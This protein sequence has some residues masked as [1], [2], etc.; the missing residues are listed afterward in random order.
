MKYNYVLAIIGFICGLVGAFIALGV[1]VFSEDLI[2]NALIALISSI[3]GI[4]GIWLFNQDV[5][6]A[7]VLYLI[8]AVGVLIGV[9]LFGI[10]GF[11]FFIG[12][13]IAC[14]MEKTKSEAKPNISPNTQVHIFG[15]QP[16]EEVPQFVSHNTGKFWIIHVILVVLIIGLVVASSGSLFST[17]AEENNDLNVT[18][19][20]VKHSVLNMYNVSC[21]IVPQKDFTYLEMQVIFYDSSDAVIGK[22]PL[23]WNINNPVTN[24]TIKASGTAITNSNNAHPVRAEV[25]FY[26]K[27]LGN[28]NSTNA[29]YHETVNMTNSSK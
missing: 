20:T 2:Y 11:I 1:S 16:V 19:L 25:Y 27:A 29:I 22:S 8:S 26:D 28:D 4:I 6:Q 13:A 12:A 9:S 3:F 14:Y 15:D 10:P 17:P 24:E 21:N 7:M 23:V 5:M 18:D